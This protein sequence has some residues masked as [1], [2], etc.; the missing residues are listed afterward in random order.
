MRR[1]VWILLGMFLIPGLVSAGGFKGKTAIGLQAGYFAPSFDKVNDALQQMKQE[2]GGALS[3]D[4]KVGA[5]LDFGASFYYGVGDKLYLRAE[6][7]R[8]NNKAELSGSDETGSATLAMEY[9]LT[10]ILF[11]ALF[12]LS[13]NP[14]NMMLYIGGGAGVVL[15]KQTSTVSLN[16]PGQIT[17]SQSE[18]DSGNDLMF[19][20]IVGL[21]YPYSTNMSLFV[22]GRYMAGKY[23]VGKGDTADDVS[24]SGLKVMGGLKFNFG[25]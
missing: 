8:W 21:E 20:G 16:M 13:N 2:S 10:P 25:Q 19:Q 7:F 5:A 1:T 18:S 4:E 6:A 24:L 12:Y 3:G 17:G 11:S 15:V 22:E 14:G 9:T 23:T